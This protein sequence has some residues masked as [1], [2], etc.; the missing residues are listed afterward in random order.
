MTHPLSIAI[1]NFFPLTLK[2]AP[3]PEV[4]ANAL[5]ILTAVLSFLF[6]FVSNA[7]WYLSHL[8]TTVEKEEF[9]HLLITEYMEDLLK[10]VSE[11]ETL[12]SGWVFQR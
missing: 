2:K 11:M 5:L 7:N 3:P 10:D 6:Y 9:L 12:E 1:Y 4:S 8:Y